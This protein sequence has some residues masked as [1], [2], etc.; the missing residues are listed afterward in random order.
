MPPKKGKKKL[1]VQG[2][3]PIENAMAENLVN[4]IGFD[5]STIEDDAS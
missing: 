3:N 4:K 2:N 1:V 5:V